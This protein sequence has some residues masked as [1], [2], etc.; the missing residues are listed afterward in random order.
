MKLF[1]NLSS[2]VIKKS[3]HIVAQAFGHEIVQDA[4]SAEAIVTND[5]R[6]MVSLLKKGKRVV[7]FLIRPSDEPATGL[8]TA[9]PEL[10]TAC[11]VVLGKGVDGCETLI[12]FLATPNQKEKS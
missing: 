8:M 4:D 1:V 2:E 11:R 7:Q 12:N 9:Y 6:E 3:I 5:L 10:F